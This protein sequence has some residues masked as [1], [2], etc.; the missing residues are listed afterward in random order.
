MEFQYKNL[1]QRELIFIILLVV[2]LLI[3]HVYALL[4]KVLAANTNL[5]Q[6]N[7]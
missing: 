7:F 2:S 1:G 5:V 4:S 6:Q 3:T